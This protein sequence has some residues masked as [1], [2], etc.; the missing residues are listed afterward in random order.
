MKRLSITSEEDWASRPETV[1]IAEAAAVI[2]EPRLLRLFH[3]WMAR[4]RDGR[5]PA[6]TDI[7]PRALGSDV[8]PQIVL[9][10]CL[11]R[12]G[13]ADCRYRLVGTALVDRLGVDPTGRHMSEVMADPTYADQLIRMTHL[14]L[15][16]GW[17]VFSAGEHVSRDDSLP[18]RATRRL[19]MPMQPL[20]DGTAL[21]LAGQVHVSAGRHQPTTAEMSPTYRSTRF[22]SFTG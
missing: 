14:P 18:R 16:T 15:A 17:P 10:E 9:F 6:R 5:P 8:L 4:R 20:P 21:V 2:D 13:R 7:D 12:E 11:Q 3:F 22:V 19:T 1:D